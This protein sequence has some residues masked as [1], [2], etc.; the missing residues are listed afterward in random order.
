MN[1]DESRRVR[2]NS[3]RDNIRNENSDDENK[4]MIEE[5][6]KEILK[7]LRRAR[8][9]NGDEIELGAL[10]ADTQRKTNRLIKRYVEDEYYGSEFHNAL[11]NVTSFLSD[12]TQELV[13]GDSTDMYRVG[14]SVASAK[15]IL[16]SA[17]DIYEEE[18]Y[19]KIWNGYY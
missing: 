12:A 7:Q 16:D 5:K 6:L 10:I 14:L 8:Q 18:G 3:H 4:R 1:E 2:N 17:I 9:M 15:Q 19:G 11:E 13:S